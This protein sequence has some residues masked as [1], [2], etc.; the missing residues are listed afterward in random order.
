MRVSS[1]SCLFA[2]AS[3][4]ALASAVPAT[5]Q[6]ETQTLPSQSADTTEQAVAETQV[7]IGDIIVTARK[8]SESLQ[9][10][11]ASILAI[12]GAE[13]QSL[14]AKSLIDLN[15]VTPNASIDP[16]GNLTIR[17][18]S[19][20]A[21]NSGFEA[22]AAVY[23]D[24]V[25]Q[26]RPYGN[27]QDLTDIARLEVLRGP[28]G[29]LYGKNTTAGAISLVTVRPG[30]TWTGRAEAQYAERD[31]VRVSG[32]VAGPL[33]P[34]LLGVKV[35]AFRRR[36]DGYQRNLT[37][38]DRYGNENSV[39]GRGELRFTP[40]SWD[41]SLRGDIRNY[42]SEPSIGEPVS[43]FAEAFSPGRDTVAFDA[44][45]NVRIRGG[46]VSLTVDKDLGGFGLTTITAGRSL[47]SNLL[48]DDDYSP[49]DL[50]YHRFT[51]ASRQ[52]SQEVRLA[53][54]STGRFTWV[55]GG[56]Y[57]HQK[58]TSDRPVT[59]SSGF[60][61]PGVLNDIVTVKTNAYAAF[62][63]A[64]YRFTDK[65]TLNLGVRYTKEDKSLDFVQLG[66]PAL[67][68]PS[69][70]IIDSMK[71]SDLSP[72]AAL[73]YEFSRGFTAYVKYSSGFKSGGW[74]PDITTTTRIGFGP[75]K[76][77]NFEAGVRTRFLNDRLGVNVTA[78][79]MNYD[80][81]QV[82]QFLGTFVGYV[83][84]N[85]GKAKIRGIEAE[86]QARPTRWLSISSGAAYNDARYTD[87]D[88]G[89][90][91]VFSGQQ[92]T[93]TPKFTGF[94][95]GDVRFPVRGLGQIEAHGDV[96]YQSREFFDDLRTVSPIGAFAGPA[97]ALANARIGLSFEN[98][99][100][101][102]VFG[103]NLTN[104]RVLSNRGPDTLGLGLVLDQYGPPRQFGGRIVYKF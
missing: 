23:I 20:N 16:G 61:F 19:S 33:I 56:F 62:A 58:L 104:K 69:L 68:Y 44:P 35:A 86:V 31:D 50:V 84:T 51:D 78:Y 99:I 74:N 91:V 18:I 49:V 89:T 103:T 90:G 65:L 5:A 17:G 6:T 67:G 7:G 3:V 55:I 28:Q 101:L 75:E 36:A 97:Y 9:D 60:P 48:F 1:K 46:G 14:N 87:F 64:D 92:F 26:G 76:V 22:G 93:Q 42:K 8:R 81:L 85:A 82:S 102:S 25:Y 4:G 10:V 39:G 38:G 73:T 40:G 88:T 96:R 77:N 32:Y 30:D 100:E 37:T 63:N 57:F 52:Y 94:V 12:G 27:N 47:K 54:P 15:G 43:G 2:C 53:S 21:R 71:D 70:D 59:L 13:I 11:P 45:Y 24:G 98:G 66:V 72:T 83:I 95:S 29:T 34:D 80:D 79:T 41:I